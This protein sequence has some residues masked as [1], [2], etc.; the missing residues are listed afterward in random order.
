MLAFFDDYIHSVFS[1]V[2]KQRKPNND[3]ICHNEV[4]SGLLK[5]INNRGEGK[6]ENIFAH[7]P[8]DSPLMLGEGK[9]DRFSP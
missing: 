4:I 9:Q 5:N 2:L 8:T 7:K 6:V 3:S 1:W